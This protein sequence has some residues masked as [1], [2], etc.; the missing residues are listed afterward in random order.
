MPVA[1]WNSVD[2][3]GVGVVGRFGPRLVPAAGSSGAAPL[4]PGVMIPLM[5]RFRL[6]PVL[7]LAVSSVLLPACTPE[8]EVEAPV[9]LVDEAAAAIGGNV[10]DGPE[11]NGTVAVHDASSRARASTDWP[12]VELKSGEA[13]I[14]C[15]TDYVEKGDGEQLMSLAHAD[16]M[17]ALEPC[18]ERGMVRLRYRGRIAAD[19][20]DLIQRVTD[21]AIRQGISKRVLDIDSFGGQ[22]EDAIRAGD[23]IADSAWTIWVRENASCHSACVFVLA[24]GDNRLVSGRVGIHRII[25][26]SSTAT[27]RSE[28]NKELRGVHGRVKEYFERN[29]VAVA[30]ADLMMSVPNRNLRLLNAEEL[31][32][33]GLDGTNAAQDDLERLQQMR[34]CGEAFVLRKDAFLRAFG[35]RCKL[36]DTDLDQVHACG[37]ELRSQYGF[38][39][40]I[41]PADSPFSEFDF[42]DADP[43]PGRRVEVSLDGEPEEDKATL[44]LKD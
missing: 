32:E 21:V 38:P 6:F 41:C 13:F 22:V 19:F 28:L 12:E 44:D 4:L 39:D 31:R 17:A 15:E 42:P 1:R 30:V 24:A 7:L 33:Y 20:T 26:M 3:A 8:P 34:K 18:K 10:S 9:L 16:V 2:L 11:G 36:P 5:T 14:G 35:R 40:E 29:G 27:S 23:I 37:L 25:R 43:A